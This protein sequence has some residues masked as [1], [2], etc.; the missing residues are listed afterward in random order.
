[1]QLKALNALDEG[2]Q[3]EIERILQVRRLYSHRN[4][5]VDEKFLKYFPGEFELNKEHAMSVAKML[6][7]LEYLAVT[8]DRIDVVAIAQYS[9]AAIN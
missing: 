2:Q 7:K 4:G 1:M 8:V 3:D 6:E 9:L 5:I